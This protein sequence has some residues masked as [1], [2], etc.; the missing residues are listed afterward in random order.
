MSL[1]YC[2]F[3]SSPYKYSKTR[4]NYSMICDQCGDELIKAPFINITQV[5]GLIGA[6][7]FIVPFLLQI[8][9]LVKELNHQRIKNSFDQITFL[10]FNQHDEK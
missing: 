2:P 1:Y 7:V 3:C 6:A 10:S 5:L 8:A 4:S 9:F